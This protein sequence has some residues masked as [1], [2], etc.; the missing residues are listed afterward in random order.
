MFP[1]QYDPP[2]F[3]PPSEG[4]SLLLQ[5][6]LGCSHNACTYCMMYR[7]KTFQVRERRD[8][9]AEIDGVAE[10]CQRHGRGPEKVFLCDGDALA[11][12][13]ELLRDVTEKIRRDLPTVRR[14]GIY[15]TVDNVLQKSPEELQALARAGLNIAGCDKVLKKVVKGNDAAASVRAASILHDAGWKISTIIMLG[16]GG[17]E[18]SASH[19]QE[20]ARILSAIRPAWFSFLTTNVLPGSPLAKRQK[21][22]VFTPL[23]IRELLAEMRAILAGLTFP[24]DDAVVFRANHVSNQYPIGG[25]LPADQGQL[26][27]VLDD[28]VARCPEGTY[29]DNDPSML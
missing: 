13:F 27:R 29:P 14:L 19:C 18:D 10:L 24:D 6:T 23:T 25:T 21:R 3:R 7:T 4:R 8:L 17:R 11:A 2:V 26:V 20:T 9:F 15:A 28:W 22:G 16:I 12:P 5:V 1:L